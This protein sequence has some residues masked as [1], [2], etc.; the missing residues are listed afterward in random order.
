MHA[1]SSKLVAQ[2][3]PT[4][5]GSRWQMRAEVFEPKKEEIQKIKEKEK[6]KK[7]KLLGK[8]M[9][10]KDVATV[11][12]GNSNGEA[13]VIESDGGLIDVVAAGDDGL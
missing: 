10:E 8:N 12:D 5:E 11:G 3:P 6:T 1:S 13:G 4:P 7:R 2:G 9:P